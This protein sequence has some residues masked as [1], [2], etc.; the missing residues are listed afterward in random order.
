MQKEY[1]CLSGHTF[2]FSKVISHYHHSMCNACIFILYRGEYSWF[3]NTFSFQKDIAHF[4]KLP[5][6]VSDFLGPSSEPNCCLPLLYLSPLRPLRA[7][8]KFWVFLG[9]LG[10]PDP[11]TRD[12][13]L[14]TI[15]HLLKRHVLCIKFSITTEDMECILQWFSLMEKIRARKP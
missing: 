10:F 3:S 13:V 1:S 4:N 11:K 5:V 2:T 8:Q 12:K 7:L 14:I 15:S 6:N 9:I